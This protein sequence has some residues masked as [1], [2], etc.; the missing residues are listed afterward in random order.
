M[1]KI[2]IRDPLFQACLE[3]LDPLGCLDSP[4]IRDR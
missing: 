2:F 4:G 1:G 3:S